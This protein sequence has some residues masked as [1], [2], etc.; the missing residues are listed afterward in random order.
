[1]TYRQA[2]RKLGTRT[3]RRACTNGKI[4]QGTG[5]G[6]NQRMLCYKYPRPA[7]RLGPKVRRIMAKAL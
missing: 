7:K 5:G 6:K 2:R 3:H 4:M 1:M